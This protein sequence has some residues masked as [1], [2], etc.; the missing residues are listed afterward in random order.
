MYD[1][2][3]NKV[4]IFQSFCMG[5]ATLVPIICF[6]KNKKCTYKQKGVKKVSLRTTVFQIHVPM[7]QTTV[8]CN[9]VPASITSYAM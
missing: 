1:W 7:E 3:R 9:V 8:V 4:Q 6:G 5:A 2:A